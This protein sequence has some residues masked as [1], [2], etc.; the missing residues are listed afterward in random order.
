M[1]MTIT[2]GGSKNVTNSEK[3]SKIVR[4]KGY[5]LNFRMESTDYECDHDHD[6][7]G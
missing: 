3:D 1:T 4:K 6:H 2:M 7:G 5:I